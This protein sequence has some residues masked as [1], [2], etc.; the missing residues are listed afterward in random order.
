MPILSSNNIT[1][2]PC[3]ASLVNKHINLETSLKDFKGLIREHIYLS[4]KKQSSPQKLICFTPP[5]NIKY[6]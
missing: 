2:F 3:C 5:M 6:F 4:N 1:V